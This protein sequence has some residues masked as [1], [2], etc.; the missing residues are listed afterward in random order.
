MRII[1]F[2]S[3]TLIAGT[4][5]SLYAFFAKSDALI[6]SRESKL[7]A[8]DIFQ[9]YTLRAIHYSIFAFFSLYPFLVDL[10]LKHDL[11]IIGMIVLVYFQ[12]KLF[13]GCVLII[14]EKRILFREDFEE[15]REYKLPFL[16]L[17]NVPKNVTELSDNIIFIQLFT[18]GLRVWYSWI[19]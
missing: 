7:R 15:N 11:F 8:T 4:I 6:K 14:L 10:N 19:Y 9:I 17:L 3:N 5:A 2:C 18:L 12:W 1:I 16:A 13:S